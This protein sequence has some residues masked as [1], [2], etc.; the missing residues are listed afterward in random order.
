MPAERIAH[1]HIGGQAV[2]EGVMMRG[3]Y[4]WGIAV[5][6][7]DGTIHVEQH[8][9]GGGRTGWMRWP[10]VRGVVTLVDTITLA[11]Q[12]FSISAVQA[13]L[14]AVGEEEEPLTKREI[15]I[16]LAIGLVLAVG[17]F[18]LL[19]AGVTQLMTRFFG[20][21]NFLWNLVDGLIRIG[22]F[23]LYILAVSR[24][25]DIQ[26]LFAYHGAEHKTIHA[27][28]HGLPLEP[29]SIQRFET[30]HVRCG[31]SFLL[32]VMII[33]ILVYSVIP[34][35][36]FAGPFGW[37]LSLG[38]RVGIRLLLLPVIAGLA[39]EVVKFAGN[40]TS[41]PIVRV[42]LWPGLMLQKMT[43]RE[44]D[45]S[46]VEVAVMAVRPVLEREEVGVALVEGPW[47]PPEERAEEPAGPA[48]GLPDRE[49]EP[50]AAD[51]AF[52]ESEPL[53]SLTATGEAKPA[54]A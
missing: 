6:R 54:D 12:A 29:E 20:K 45:D 5:R 34:V 16:S 37:G 41:N 24:M 33:A 44:P 21:S 39:Y 22:I 46:M 19:P 11:M 7:G 52:E 2:L 27:Y 51:E 48:D 28:E 17:L 53:E 35:F 8:E 13:S 31:T 14:G 18:I 26:R 50:P 15:S 10:V 43:T 36:T 3:K 23:F 42:M 4:N 38:W 49:L 32:M 1:T 40:H 9:L 30:M 47:T 25:K